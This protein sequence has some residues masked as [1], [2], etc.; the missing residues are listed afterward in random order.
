MKMKNA[1]VFAGILIV[2][3]LAATDLSA[4]ERYEV[5]VTNLT[6]GQVITPPVVFSHMSDYALF[7]EG[8]K[9]RSSLVMLAEMGATDPLMEV[10]TTKD[11]VYDVVAGTGVILPGKSLSVEVMTDNMFESITAVG[12]LAQTNDSFFAIKNIMAPLEGEKVVYANAYDAGSEANNEMSAYVP[13]PPFGGTLR[14]TGNAEKFVHIHAG[15]HGIADLMS[16]MYDWRNPVAKVVIRRI[17]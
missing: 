8:E 13:G 17:D 2:L 10:L 15:I 11:R 16:S 7:T 6:R 3:G 12:M 14:A 1:I 4:V 5:T 9:A